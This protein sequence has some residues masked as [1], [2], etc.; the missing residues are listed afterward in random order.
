LRKLAAQFRQQPDPRPRVFLHPK[1]IPDVARAETP[2]LFPA[3][4]KAYNLNIGSFCPRFSASAAPI[5]AEHTR[6]HKFALTFTQ[7]PFKKNCARL[8]VALQS[9]THAFGNKKVTPAT[10]SKINNS[11]PIFASVIFSFLYLPALGLQ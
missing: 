6:N 7:G 11:G 9:F 4:A 8:F 10:G 5:V 2:T 3:A 1:P